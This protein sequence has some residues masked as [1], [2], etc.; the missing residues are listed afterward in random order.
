MTQN[1]AIGRNDGSTAQVA[2]GDVQSPCECQQHP[3]ERSAALHLAK[4]LNDRDLA[5]TVN[6]T[7]AVDGPQP[8][9]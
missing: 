5:D 2:Q 4:H 3:Q 7:A 9:C 1:V 8:H 6:P